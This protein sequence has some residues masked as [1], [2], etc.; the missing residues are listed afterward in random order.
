MIAL[1]NLALDLVGGKAGRQL[2][3]GNDRNQVVHGTM[4][5]ARMAFFKWN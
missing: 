4:D 3:A 1:P 2:E 5:R